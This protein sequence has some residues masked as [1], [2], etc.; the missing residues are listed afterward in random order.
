M[1]KPKIVYGGP[2]SHEADAINREST[3]DTPDYTELVSEWKTIS[4]GA[5]DYIESLK[6]PE[7]VKAGPFVEN[8]KGHEPETA[9]RE[10]VDLDKL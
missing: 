7:E 5:H 3:K 10:E 8:V 9:P 4:Q 6:A 2:F 1:P